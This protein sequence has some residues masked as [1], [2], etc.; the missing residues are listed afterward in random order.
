MTSRATK[1]DLKRW[2]LEA[3]RAEGGAAT[4]LQ[5]A[6]R[7]WRDHEQDFRAAG[8]LFYTWQYDMRWCATVLRHEGLFAPAV[9]GNGVWRLAE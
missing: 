7:L 1:D 2:V 8:A 5:V 9:R 3:V 4:V 6:E